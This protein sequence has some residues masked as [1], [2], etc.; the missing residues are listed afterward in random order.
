MSRELDHLVR[1]TRH[2]A[3]ASRRLLQAT[4]DVIGTNPGEGMR[5]GSRLIVLRKPRRADASNLNTNKKR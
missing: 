4:A 3:D 1:A 5:A 2:V